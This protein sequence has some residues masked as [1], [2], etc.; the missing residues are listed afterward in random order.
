MKTTMRSKIVVLSLAL[1]TLPTFAQATDAN[2]VCKGLFEEKIKSL[3]KT[4]EKRVKRVKALRTAAVVSV[5]AVPT[6]LF[7]FAPGTFTAVA[8]FA[9]GGTFIGA[10]VG[11]SIEWI[12]DTGDNKLEG[13]EKAYDLQEDM[14]IPYEAALE[15]D[16]RYIAERLEAVLLRFNNEITHRQVVEEMTREVNEQ[17]LRQSRAALSE[18]EVVA[19]KRA[20]LIKRYNV[21][22]HAK[23]TVTVALD[24]LKEKKRVAKN[25]EYEEFREILIANQDKFCEGNEARNFRSA[26]K[27]IFPKN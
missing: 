12:Q 13:Y 22:P 11:G 26:L 2:F 27:E 25:M 15:D 3:E 20:E 14:F 16:R 17:R 4:S 8:M 10:A 1:M 6:T 18:E 9:G 24:Y 21:K 19:L 5:A 23:N 7:A